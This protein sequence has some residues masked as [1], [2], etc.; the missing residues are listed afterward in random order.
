MRAGHD[1]VDQVER[2]ARYRRRELDERAG[3]HKRERAESA[4]FNRGLSAF[5]DAHA[6]RRRVTRV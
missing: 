6:T 5:H 1:C 3:R 2:K 4:V